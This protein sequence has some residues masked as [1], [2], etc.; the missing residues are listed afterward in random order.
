M[1]SDVARGE[2]RRADGELVP[3]FR[4]SPRALNFRE[5]GDVFLLKKDIDFGGQESV[6][7]SERIVEF[8]VA[9]FNVDAVFNG[10]SFKNCFSSLPC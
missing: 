3:K 6:S 2:V 10:F 9:G 8:E 5:R 4:F 1:S 7:N